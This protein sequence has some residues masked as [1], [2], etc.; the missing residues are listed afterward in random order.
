MGNINEMTAAQLQEQ[1][2]TWYKEAEENGILRKIY[3]IGVYL[4]ERLPAKWGPK[5]QFYDKEGCLEIYVDDYGNYFTA[6]WKG[7][8]VLS[9][10]PCTHL[11]IPGLWTKI[12]ERLFPEAEA[13]KIGIEN[14]AE[15][16]E[17]LELLKELSLP[18]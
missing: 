18:E 3:A 13:V 8:S 12:V 14:A 7:K 5:Y 2:Q 9:T 15:E 17:K 16:G 11:F 4:G 6:R 1:K 10:H